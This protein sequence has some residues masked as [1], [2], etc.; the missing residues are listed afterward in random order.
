MNSYLTLCLV[1]GIAAAIAVIAAAG[2][3][4]VCRNN[5]RQNSAVDERHDTTT[6]NRLINDQYEATGRR[7]AYG[8]YAARRNAC[9]VIAVHNAK[10]LMGRD[11]TLS[12]TAADFQAAGAM[13]GYGLFG[14]SPCAIGRV[15][16]RS[17]M[18]YE[19]IGLADMTRPG[20]YILS[21][22]NRHAPW[23]GLHT[24]AVRYDG[25]HYATYNLKGRGSV[26][27]GPPSR[28]ARHFICG[29]Y[30]T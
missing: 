28:Y 1:C 5:R 18:A 17:G 26:S 30:L 21:F 2:Y 8:L 11:S 7:F 25:R 13:I 27:A 22:W 15:L 24:V 16:R 6:R 3:R 20:V 19:R 10:V 12:R 14:S 9:E 4:L 29:Y 23:G